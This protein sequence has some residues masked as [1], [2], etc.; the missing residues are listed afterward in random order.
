M[1]GRRHE[2]VPRAL[3]VLL[4]QCCVGQPR[5]FWTLLQGGLEADTAEAQLGAAPDF[6]SCEGAGFPAA[7]SKL[8]EQLARRPLGA[9]RLQEA[10]V[11]DAGLLQLALGRAEACTPQATTFAEAWKEYYWLMRHTTQQQEGSTSSHV[12]V[13][14]AAILR[15]WVVPPTSASADVA[16]PG[17]AAEDRFCLLG[18]VAALWLVG[19]A[20]AAR[21][22]EQDGALATQ[23]A[24]V[25]LGIVV[26]WSPDTPHR[27]GDAFVPALGR[28]GGWLRPTLEDVTQGLQAG[29][30]RGDPDAEETSFKQP[31]GLHQFGAV[32]LARRLQPCDPLRDVCWSSL[33]GAQDLHTLAEQRQVSLVVVGEHAM[34]ALD[35]Y[36]SL[37]AAMPEGVLSTDVKFVGT[38]YLCGGLDKALGGSFC[39]RDAAKAFLQSWV[40]DWNTDAVAES[41][42]R[43]HADR[44]RGAVGDA[45]G[46][47]ADLYLC[48]DHLVF[49]WLLRRRASQPIVAPMLHVVGMTLL[50]YVPVPW[51]G[52]LLADFWSWSQEAE[53]PSDVF[54]TYME[55]ITLQAFWQTGVVMQFVPSLGSAVWSGAT[56]DPP[57]VPALLIMRSAFWRLPAGMVMRTLLS[58]LAAP[59]LPLLWMD[60]FI[61]GSL[62]AEGYRLSWH[63]WE[64]QAHCTAVLHMPQEISQIKFRD[65]YALGVPI[66]VP[67]IV[68]SLRLLREMYRMWGQLHPEYE[69]RL[70]DCE[71][72]KR[73]ACLGAE[74]RREADTW[75]FGKPYVDVDRDPA[76]KL[77]FWYSLA[78]VARYPHVLRFS[79]LAELRLLALQQADEGRLLSAL[80][81]RHFE[82]TV[83][84]N[85]LRFFRQAVATLLS[86]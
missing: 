42:A 27:W 2:L 26:P 54:C 66:L 50:E 3:C 64:Q 17:Q 41:S 19:L 40:S 79:S 57:R 59:D 68:W 1:R 18:C 77:E 14:A 55:H 73:Q 31:V 12:Q 65:F 78:D 62:A 5:P 15:P 74:A 44:F 7:W 72:G 38:F 9:R 51:R 85:S 45:G 34:L 13:P 47:R 70:R 61:H 23:L 4:F 52:E 21:G 25:L 43:D 48:V 28:W 63:S 75:P 33:H 69:H 67:G 76:E 83:V 58:H 20:E 30:R 56:Y 71:D 10:A 39:A 46:D 32:A 29:P 80:M 11:T 6:V 22:G 81:R 16:E 8:K 37:L 82:R 86:T 53:A 60:S 84:A 49:C 24:Q 36:S 35:L